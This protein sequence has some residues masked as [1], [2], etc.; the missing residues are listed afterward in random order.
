MFI[1]EAMAQG[2][3][4]GSGFLIQIA[5]LVL[6]FAVFYFLLIRPQ[7]KKMKDHRSMV[8][9]LTKGDK[10][11]TAGGLLGT[12]AKIEDERI[13]S[14]EISDNVKVKVVRSTITE[15]ISAN[16]ASKNNTSKK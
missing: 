5:P 14:V 13:A 8:D 1:S 3:G 16:N 7:Q 12:I 4:G 2:A 6:I 15:V 9:S 11:V 10:V